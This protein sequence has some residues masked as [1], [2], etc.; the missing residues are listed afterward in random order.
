MDGSDI[1]APHAAPA[2]GLHESQGEQDLLLCTH[3]TPG[4]IH[5]GTW[6][7]RPG[8]EESIMA[9]QFGVF[10]HIEPIPGQELDQIYRDRLH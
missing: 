3:A 1:M 9:L 5:R 8:R 10:D 7:H 6:H 2:R 4:M